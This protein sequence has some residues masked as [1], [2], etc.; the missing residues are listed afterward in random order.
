MFSPDD[1][2]I[3][4]RLADGDLRV[5]DW[6]SRRLLARS[7]C[8][9]TSWERRS[10]DF[11]PD[12][13]TLYF[14]D[15]NG[16]VSRLE[17]D[18]GTLSSAVKSGPA[19]LVRLS[20][21][22]R[23][24]L[25]T[26]VNEVQWE[27][28]PPVTVHRGSSRPSRVNEVQVWEVDPPRRLVLTNFASFPPS[29]LLGAA[30]HPNEE[31]LV[32]GVKNGLFLW[33]WPSGEQKPFELVP[34]SYPYDPRFNRVGD[35]LFVGGQVWDVATQRRV[36][37]VQVGS[38]LALSA[39]ETRMALQVV[40]TGF[41]VWE[42]LPPLGV[43]VFME[44]PFVANLSHPDL[45]PN[46]RWLAS[47]QADGWRVWDSS[48]GR[49]LARGPDV[50]VKEAKF[51]ADSRGL[52]TVGED[53]LKRWPLSTAEVSEGSRITVGPAEFLLAGIP[54]ELTV[55]TNQRPDPRVSQQLQHVPVPAEYGAITRGGHFAALSGNGDAVVVEVAR[56]HIFPPIRLRNADV[57]FRL[58]PD[59]RWL[60]TGRHNKPWFDLWEVGAGRHALQITNPPF[61]TC[62]FHPATSELIAWNQS[63]LIVR[64]PDL[65]SEIRRF[66]WPAGS[67]IG[68]LLP[69]GRGAKWPRA[70]V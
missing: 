53:G 7:H 14:G 64:A 51:T 55:D 23:R 22:G 43:R 63:E 54:S 40:K 47:A 10:F 62:Q 20:P 9:D 17:L 3:A 19:S 13:R 48:N 46:G 28:D 21:S 60:A 29:G 24:L 38:F 33:H 52:V 49:V 32:L 42:F 8:G 30:W 6:R 41:G 39:D 50:V 36:L 31:L 34:S 12:S 69:G 11:S 68:G 5:W 25:T 4:V 61:L 16:G 1:R 35:L 2:W 27:V 37:A 57:E 26:S 45:A 70:L 58:S 56:T 67:L 59:G 18:T 66:S 15:T 44:N 65:V